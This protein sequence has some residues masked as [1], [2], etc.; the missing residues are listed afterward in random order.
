MA[1]TFEIKL[2]FPQINMLRAFDSYWYEA[3]PREQAKRD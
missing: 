2:T 3:D 1:L